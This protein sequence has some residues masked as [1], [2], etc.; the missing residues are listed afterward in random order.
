MPLYQCFH[1]SSECRLNR[2]I[3][4]PSE[5]ESHHESDSEE[6]VVVIPKADYRTIHAAKVLGVRNGDTVRAGLVSCEKD[7][8]GLLCDQAIVEWLPEGKVKKA[9]PLRNGDP[10]GS[11]QL[12]LQSLS[13][14]APIYDELMVS[15][16]LALPRPLQLGRILPMISQMGVDKLVLTNA[17]KVPKD[18]FGSHLFRKPEVLREKLIEGLCQCGDV[19]RKSCAV[20]PAIISEIS[21]IVADAFAFFYKKC[22]PSILSRIFRIFSMKS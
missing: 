12:R 10:P 16:I 8:G 19:R 6:K 2:F 18:Y 17:Q 22:Q 7:K 13:P 11:L 21:N 9:E 14:P 5:V 1:S 4:D 20:A 3:F 15:L